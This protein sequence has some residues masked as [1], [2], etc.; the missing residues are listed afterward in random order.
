[1]RNKRI[2]RKHNRKFLICRKCKLLRVMRTRVRKSNTYSVGML[3]YQN[4]KSLCDFSESLKKAIKRAVEQ[5]GH[6]FEAEG[7]VL[8]FWDK[9][10]D[11]NIAYGSFFPRTAGETEL[12]FWVGL[13]WKNNYKTDD[14][15]NLYNIIFYIYIP[16]NLLF[17]CSKVTAQLEDKA[18]NSKYY[19][20]CPDINYTVVLKD[21]YIK[22]LRLQTAKKEDLENTLSQF[23]MEILKDLSALLSLSYFLCK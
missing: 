14:V 20:L 5:C 1:M 9:N 7:S 4:M 11:G 12:K 15:S 22:P 2:R 6:Q 18:K 21:Q 23:I 8:E 16:V 3:K 17:M 13:H 19:E 10:K